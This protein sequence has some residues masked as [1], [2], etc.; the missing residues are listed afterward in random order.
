MLNDVLFGL[1]RNLLRS[2]GL[3]FGKASFPANPEAMHLY[4][5]NFY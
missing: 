1:K 3:E 5:P 2:H 4:R